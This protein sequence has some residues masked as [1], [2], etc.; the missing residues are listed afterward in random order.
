MLL[1]VRDNA[2]LG[3]DADGRQIGN[4]IEVR[5]I[6]LSFVAVERQL[7]DVATGIVGPYITHITKSPR[8]T[9]VGI[10]HLADLSP[11]IDEIEREGIHEVRTIG[12]LEDTQHNTFLTQTVVTGRPPYP[13]N[14]MRAAQIQSGPGVA[15]VP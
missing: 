13:G 1:V 4:L 8:T 5:I 2:V 11:L 15:S 6:A 9:D 7:C 10:R 12:P 14:D 3:V